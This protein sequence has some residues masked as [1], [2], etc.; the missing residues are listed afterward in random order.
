M[1]GVS[2]SFLECL[3]EPSTRTKIQNGDELRGH[4]TSSRDV[5]VQVAV[6]TISS[7][8]DLDIPDIQK[9]PQ[10]LTRLDMWKQNNGMVKT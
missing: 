1:H 7:R 10:E 4:S 3:H 5:H 8:P 9:L 2:I 6:N